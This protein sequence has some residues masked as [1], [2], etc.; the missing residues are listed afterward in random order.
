MPSV[1][2][3]IFITFDLNYM[4]LYI[5]SNDICSLTLLNNILSS[6]D[7]GTESSATPS[8]ISLSTFQSADKTRLGQTGW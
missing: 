4:H 3:C 5:H 6:F 1:K 2:F 8:Q 7:Y